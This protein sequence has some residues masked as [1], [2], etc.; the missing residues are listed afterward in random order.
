MAELG[1]EA[2]IARGRDKQQAAAE[3]EV[4]ELEVTTTA[5]RRASPPRAV[6]VAWN[7]CVPAPVRAIAAPPAP[8]RGTPVR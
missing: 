6:A 8:S 1:A 4:E 3:E 2:G 5:A 7:P